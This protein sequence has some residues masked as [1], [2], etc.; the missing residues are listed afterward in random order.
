MYVGQ[1]GLG[2]GTWVLGPYE[3]V[4]RVGS[5]VT[6]VLRWSTWVRCL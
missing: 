6:H 5:K 4:G 1:V 3:L 2:L